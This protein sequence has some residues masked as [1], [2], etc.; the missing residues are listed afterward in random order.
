MVG[1][2]LSEEARGG[3]RKDS[4]VSSPGGTG[5]AE[6]RGGEPKKEGKGGPEGIR[7]GK[8]SLEAV[9]HDVFDPA[10]EYVQVSLFGLVL[11]PSSNLSPLFFYLTATLKY[12]LH[13]S[14]TFSSFPSIH[15]TSDRSRHARS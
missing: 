12:T 9:W 15:F 13:P 7:E 2:V 1:S 14:P 3:G 8:N 11:I 4:F 6:G 5:V 10:M